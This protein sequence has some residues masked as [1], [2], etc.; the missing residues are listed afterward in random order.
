MFR[1]TFL[2]FRSKSQDIVKSLKCRADSFIRKPYDD[3]YLLSRVEYI[4]TNVQLR[5]TA[6]LDRTIFISP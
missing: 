1:S 6:V 5:K 4:L 3:K 2:T